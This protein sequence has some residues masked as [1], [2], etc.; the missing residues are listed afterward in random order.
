MSWKM[1]D[2]AWDE[3]IEVSAGGTFKFSR[4]CIPIFRKQGFGRIIN[5]TSV[6][7]THGN[8]GQVNYSTAKAGIIGFTKTAA[9]ELAKFGITVNAISPVAL[10]QMLQGVPKEKL[11]MIE[12]KIPMGRIAR[13]DEICSA[14]AFL[15]SQEAKYVTGIVVP[16][17]GGLSI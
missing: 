3:V 9:L 11:A 8:I 14:V 13:P 7:G 1:S 16:V 5:F 6:A 4:A 2:D 10:T 17:D 12:E 15:A